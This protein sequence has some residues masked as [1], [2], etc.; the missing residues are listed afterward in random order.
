ML[1][2]RKNAQSFCRRWNT[3]S[4]VVRGLHLT[5]TATGPHLWS[6]R[7]TGRVTSFTARRGWPRDIPYQWSHMAWV[8]SPLSGT[9]GRPTPESLSQVMLMTL[10]REAHSREFN[11]ILTT[12]LCKGPVGILS[13]SDQDHIGRVS[14]EY[15]ARRGLLPQVRPGGHH[16]DQLLR[17]LCWGRG[18]SGLVVGE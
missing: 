1:S 8:S 16:G 15:P 13:G 7:A 3:S 18:G 17:R 10:G 9:S 12:W 6:G 4:P 5:A 11:N 2:M 14:M